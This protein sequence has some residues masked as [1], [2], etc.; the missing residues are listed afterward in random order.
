M[1]V[2]DYG[3][4]LIET[5]HDVCPLGDKVMPCWVVMRLEFDGSGRGPGEWVVTWYPSRPA[6]RE[7]YRAAVDA[8]RDAAVVFAVVTADGNVQP[9]QECLS[10]VGGRRGRNGVLVWRWLDAVSTAA[11]LIAMRRDGTNAVSWTSQGISTRPR[12]DAEG[13]PVYP[14]APQGLGV[15]ADWRAGVG[16]AIA[17]E[18]DRVRQQRAEGK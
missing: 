3:Y 18:N 1:S 4:D 10:P 15:L 11:R 17:A 5:E 13:N 7:A 2:Y 8:I 9:M 12:R 14:P 6:A 16:E